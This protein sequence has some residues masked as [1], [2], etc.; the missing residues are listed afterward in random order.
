MS[1]D[2]RVPLSLCAA[3]GAPNDGAA[4][5]DDAV[6]KDG[7]VSICA[8]CGHLAIFRTDLSLRAITAAEL[9]KLCEDEEIVRLLRLRQECFGDIGRYSRRK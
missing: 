6:P 4:A 9:A 2:N 5:K 8:Y 7:D 1:K 3:C